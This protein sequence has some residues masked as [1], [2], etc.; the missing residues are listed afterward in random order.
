MSQKRV[1]F[2]QYVGIVGGVLI[3]ENTGKNREKHAFNLLDRSG[4]RPRFLL[5]PRRHNN[6]TQKSEMVPDTGLILIRGHH[7]V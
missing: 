2:Q 7:W 5:H 6:E 1:A 4:S 3:F